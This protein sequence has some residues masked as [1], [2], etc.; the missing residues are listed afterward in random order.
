MK[1]KINIQ[2]L[3]AESGKRKFEIAHEMGITDSYFSKMLR[4]PDEL[5][6]EKQEKIIKAIQTLKERENTK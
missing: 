2:K 1:K 4:F 5:P 6:A 3:I